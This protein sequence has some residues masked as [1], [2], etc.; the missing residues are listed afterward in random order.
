MRSCMISSG[1][2]IDIRI[3]FDKE[4]PRYV[5]YLQVF[6]STFEL[7]STKRNEDIYDIFRY[8]LWHSNYL[9]QKEKRG[10]V[11]YIQ[12]F[13]SIFELPSMTRIEDMYYIFRYSHRE[14]NYLRQRET[15]ICIISSGILINFRIIF[16]KEK[17]GYVWYLQVF[18]STFGLPSI[19]KIEDVYSHQHSDYLR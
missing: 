10:Y 1:I 18:S 3:T 8:S 7:H 2:L 4:T 12:V 14:S 13:S 16:D 15:R 19:G 11:W 6:S 17:R 5:W 9:R